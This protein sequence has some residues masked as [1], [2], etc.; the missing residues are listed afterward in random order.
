M[1]DFLTAT[2]ETLYMVLAST[3]LACIIGIPLGVLLVLMRPEGIW[4]KPVAF[5]IS[6]AVINVLRSIPFI[7]L[8][9]IIFPLTRLL[10]GRTTGTTAAIPPLTLAAAPFVARM[11]EQSFLEIDKGIIEA[12]Q[13]MGASRWEIVRTVLLPESLPSMINGIT[14]L[15]I[16]IV[17]YS[18]MAGA[19]GGGGLGDLAMR[20][21][22]YNRQPKALFVSVVIIIVLVQIIQWL[23]DLIRVKVDKK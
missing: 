1:G 14:I 3:V 8:M 5:Q 2:G 20:F 12:S 16:N 19:I 15:M 9:I 4:P 10:V 17:G 21:G 7:I 23:G 22:L 6:N 11:M 13:A 18:A